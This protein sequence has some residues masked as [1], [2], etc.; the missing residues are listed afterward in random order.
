ME[1]YQF[2]KKIQMWV[3]NELIQ[4]SGILYGNLVIRFKTLKNKILGFD[5]LLLATSSFWIE[6]ISFGIHSN[7]YKVY[8]Q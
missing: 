6:S 7:S 1:Y 5:D 4:K 2:S 8:G 3:Y